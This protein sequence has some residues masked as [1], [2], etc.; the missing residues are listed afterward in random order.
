MRTFHKNHF[1][2]W[3][4][5]LIELVDIIHMAKFL[6]CLRILTLLEILRIWRNYAIFGRER[7]SLSQVDRHWW[8]EKSMYLIITYGMNPRHLKIAFWLCFHL[9]QAAKFYIF[10]S[11]IDQQFHFRAAS[12]NS[13]LL[14]TAQRCVLPIYFP[15]DLLLWQ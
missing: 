12:W 6:A 10:L 13:I 11:T 5:Y 1:T 14:P 15:V 4:I 8:S 7:V 2:N 3:F 9:F